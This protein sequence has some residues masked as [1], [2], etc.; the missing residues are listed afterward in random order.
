MSGFTSENAR[1]LAEA[2]S[3][4]QQT[5]DALSRIKKQ[6]AETEALGAATLEELR[7]QGQQ[8]VLFL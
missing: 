3:T 6:T 5:K 1:M 2:D 8:M 7:A 4:Q